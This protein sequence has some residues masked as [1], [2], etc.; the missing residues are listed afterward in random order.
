MAG[1]HVRD[2]IQ[3]KYGELSKIRE[4]LDEA[5]DAEEQNNNLMIL[6]ELADIIGAINGY[7]EHKFQ[8]TVSIQD[9]V[10]MSEA[11][12]RAFNSGHRKPKGL[13]HD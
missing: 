5:Y 10:K 11:T 1:Y 12:Q 9:L 7:L 8:N 2:I 13:I 6:V 4:E 3:G